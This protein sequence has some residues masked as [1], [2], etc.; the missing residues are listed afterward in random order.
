M[1]NMCLKFVGFAQLADTHVCIK[2]SHLELKYLVPN[3]HIKLDAKQLQEHLV[4]NLYFEHNFK[5]L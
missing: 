2:H 4:F 5:Q 1:P 3:L